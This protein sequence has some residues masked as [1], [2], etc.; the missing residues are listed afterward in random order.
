[1]YVNAFRVNF[2]LYFFFCKNSNRKFSYKSYDLFAVKFSQS[3]MKSE[4]YQTNP[5]IT[6]S[7]ISLTSGIELSFFQGDEGFGDLIFLHSVR[8]VKKKKKK[9]FSAI[10]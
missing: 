9:R 5:K 3:K 8:S 7:T 1:M 10:F 4:K 6:S 2:H